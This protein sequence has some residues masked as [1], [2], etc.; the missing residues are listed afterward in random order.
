[1]KVTIVTSE[2]A[3]ML[4]TR[5]ETSIATAAEKKVKNFY[6]KQQ[7]DGRRES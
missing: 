3:R 1:M 2:T 5:M 6:E 4:D 7:L